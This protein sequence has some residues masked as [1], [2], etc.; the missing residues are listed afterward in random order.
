[1]HCHIWKAV[2][3]RSVSYILHFRPFRKRRDTFGVANGTSV[4]QVTPTPISNVTTTGFPVAPEPK[5]LSERVWFK[6]SFVISDLK[7]FTAYRIEIHACNHEITVGCSVAAYISARTMPEGEQCT[8]C[9]RSTCLWIRG[10][11]YCILNVISGISKR[12]LNESCVF[13]LEF[14]LCGCLGMYLRAS[15][16]HV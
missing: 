10:E 13:L 1:M 5:K 3:L 4:D 9:M 2:F 11:H 8:T 14:W 12:Y 16:H 7:H 6:E 15:S